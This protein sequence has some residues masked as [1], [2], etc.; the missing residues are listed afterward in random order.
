MDKEKN[1]EDCEYFYECDNIG[2]Y[3][4]CEKVKGEQNG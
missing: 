3:D 1:C 4:Q 2:Y